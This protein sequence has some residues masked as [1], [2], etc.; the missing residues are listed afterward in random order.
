MVV[1]EEA[2]CFGSQ[3]EVPGIRGGAGE[4]GALWRET[5]RKCHCENQPGEK[6]GGRGPAFSCC[7]RHHPQTLE[8]RFSWLQFGSKG[9]E[10]CTTIT[11]FPPH[12]RSSRW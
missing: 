11:P 10:F 8:S 3:A 2:D 6:G 1:M 12:T 5:T 7:Q 4:I 9:K